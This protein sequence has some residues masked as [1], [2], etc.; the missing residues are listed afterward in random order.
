M[1]ETHCNNFNLLIGWEASRVCLTVCERPHYR[2]P[3]QGSCEGYECDRTATLGRGSLEEDR[4]HRFVSLP[5]TKKNHNLDNKG[6]P[7]GGQEDGQK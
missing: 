7:G 1:E 6:W 4:S 3:H 2:Q 5:D